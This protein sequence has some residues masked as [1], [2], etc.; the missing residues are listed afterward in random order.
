[1]ARRD[2][3]GR[4]LSDPNLIH[5]YLLE[6]GQNQLQL[7]MDEITANPPANPQDN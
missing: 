3:P 5:Q 1:M 7:S 4:R 6:D 2:D